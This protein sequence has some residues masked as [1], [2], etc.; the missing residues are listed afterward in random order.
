MT[1]FNRLAAIVL[2]L[3]ALPTTSA[4]GQEKQTSTSP[5]SADALYCEERQLGYW[6]YCV[7]PLP[8]DEPQEPEAEPVAATQELDAITSE[9]RELKARAILYLAAG[10]LAG[11]GPRLHA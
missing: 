6:F 7:K 4:Y 2:S 1:H 11:P 5:T 8:A 9:L 10:D 3:A